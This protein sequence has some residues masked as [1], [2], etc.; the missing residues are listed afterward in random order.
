MSKIIQYSKIFIKGCL[1][2]KGIKR[3]ILYIKFA[4]LAAKNGVVYHKIDR[5]ATEY[6]ADYYVETSIPQKE[7][8]KY[9]L[10]GIP[11]YKFDFYGMTEDTINDYISDFDFYNKKNYMNFDYES[12]FEHKLNTYYLL[13]PFKSNMPKH[14]YYAKNGLFYPI[15]VDKK[16]NGTAEEILSLIRKR[17]IAAKA[18]IGGHGKGFMKLTFHNSEYY[19]NNEKH[20]EEKMIRLLHELNGYIITSYGIPSEYFRNMCGENAFAVIRISTVYDGADGPQLTSAIIRLGSKKSGLVTDYDETIMCGIDLDD[21]KLFYPIIRY[22]DNE[23]IIRKKEIEAHPDTMIPLSG[24]VCPNFETLKKLAKDI[25]AYLTVTP[26]LVMDIIPTDD[27]FEI[28]EINSHGQ[29]RIIEPF[30]PFRK[31]P[32]NCKVFKLREW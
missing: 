28:L 27:G 2:Q 20:S 29:F 12:W 26:Y 6:I 18:C 17:P 13:A 32:Y 3:K 23:G 21:G 30:Y 25:S 5:V 11:S 8:N 15:D 7:K 9:Y 31:N 16:Q 10:K 19:V 22:G 4:T 1:N 14:Y 24:T